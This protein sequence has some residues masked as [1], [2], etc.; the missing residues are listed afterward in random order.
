MKETWEASD[1]VC[2]RRLQTIRGH[3]VHD[4]ARTHYRRL[5]DSGVSAQEQ[6]D[7]LAT[8]YQRLNPVR[9]LDQVNLKES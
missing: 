3:K 7:A 1:W 5:L 4:T 2:S 9:L 8:R 6:Q